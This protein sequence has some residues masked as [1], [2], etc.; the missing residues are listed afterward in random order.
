MAWEAGGRGA[1]WIVPEADGEGARTAIKRALV[2]PKF[3]VFLMYGK[4]SSLGC[5]QASEKKNDEAVPSPVPTEG[6]SQH[7]TRGRLR[8]GPIADAS[9]LQRLARK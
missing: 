4:F 6:R 9:Q 8:H 5:E 7:E 3:S 1:G 2:S